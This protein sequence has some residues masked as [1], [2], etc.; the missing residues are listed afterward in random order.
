MVP[1][2]QDFYKLIIAFVSFMRRQRA[3]NGVRTALTALNDVNTA[4]TGVKTALNGVT[5][6]KQY[7]V[8]LP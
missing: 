8:E 6:A 7:E 3:S 4:L 2:F 1:V 5:F